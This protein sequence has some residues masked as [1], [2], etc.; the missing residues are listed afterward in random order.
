MSRAYLHA[1]AILASAVV[2]SAC[3]SSPRYDDLIAPE[4]ILDSSGAYV[5]P[6]LASGAEAPWVGRLATTDMFAQATTERA[7]R[8]AGSRLAGGGL[9]G[10]VAGEVAGGAA[11]KASREAAF[12]ALGGEEKMREESDLS[13]NTADD[14]IVWLHVNHRK[15]EGFER[16]RKATGL[17][18]PEVVD[19]WYSA[20]DNA[21]RRPESD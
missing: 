10:A 13:F 4:P 21:P 17:I 18:Y 6:Y 15:N 3:A 11:R 20:L 12:E 2:L 16:A 5:S 9:L 1:L 8:R 7:G 19:R 14:L